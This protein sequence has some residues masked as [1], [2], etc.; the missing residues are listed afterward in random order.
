M[1]QV[2]LFAKAPRG[3]RVKTRLAAEVGEAAALAAY[4]RV[5]RQVVD[6]VGARYPL[7][8]WYDPPDALP[9]MRR[10]LGG[11][12]FMP[13]RGDDLG[14]RMAHA[15]EEHFRRGDAPVIAI[16]A[17]APGIDAATIAAAEAALQ[18]AAVVLGPALD[19]GYYL[20]GLT[21]LAPELLADV[22][23]GTASVL[24]VTVARCFECDLPVKQLQPLRDLDTAA[25]LEV[26]ERG[27]G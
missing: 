8:V 15:F 25:D 7:T 6:R 10:W 13:Q 14:G 16:G 27:R 20:L 24:Q 4:R 22:P 1:T 2:L 23:W 18:E 19:G 21:R 26:L 17:D 5:G 12:E 3:G 11:R 9:D